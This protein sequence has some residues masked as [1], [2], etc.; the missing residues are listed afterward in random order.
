MLDCSKRKHRLEDTSSARWSL[1]VAFGKKT[2][3]QQGNA[4]NAEMFLRSSAALGDPLNACPSG[5]GAMHPTNE[6]RHGK[7][8]A[9]LHICRSCNEGLPFLRTRNY[10]CELCRPDVVIELSL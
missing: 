4:P 2:R 9:H 8:N 5:V 6:V 3:L 7:L 10:P 1:P